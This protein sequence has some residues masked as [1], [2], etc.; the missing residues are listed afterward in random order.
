MKPAPAPVALSRRAA[1]A[2][3]IPA[4]LLAKNV[5]PAKAL[6]AV[7]ALADLPMRRLK[8][9]KG[10]LGERH[11][12]LRCAA[13]AA[14]TCR[15]RPRARATPAGGSYLLCVHVARSVWTHCGC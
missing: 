1:L 8:L 11:C 9:P 5:Q 15:C 4:L 7:K 3:P 14:P 2:L 6:T 13:L 10:A 12:M